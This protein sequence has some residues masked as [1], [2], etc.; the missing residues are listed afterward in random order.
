MVDVKKFINAFVKNKITFFA[1]VPDSVLKSFIH[2]LNSNKKKNLTHR[3]AT[4]E[5]SAISLG[6]G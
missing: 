1:G 2:C 3:V 6:I 5:G 4:N